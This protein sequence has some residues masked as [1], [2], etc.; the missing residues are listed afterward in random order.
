MILKVYIYKFKIWQSIPI[1]CIKE[2]TSIT[3]TG[4]SIKG[5]SWPF[6]DNDFFFQ[7]SNY[8]TGNSINII[9]EITCI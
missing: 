5:L 7:L 2:I 9:Y 6:G 8:P 4:N 3:V 1:I